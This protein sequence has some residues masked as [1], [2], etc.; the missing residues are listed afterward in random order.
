VPTLLSYVAIYVIWGSTFLAIRMAVESIP[1][2]LMMGVRCTVAGALLIAAGA[3]RRERPTLGDWG[4]GVVAGA[5][6]F[7]VPYAALGWAE[8]RIASGTAALLVATVP[9]WLVLVEWAR[10][11]RPSPCGLAGFAIGFGGVALLVAHAWATPA[12]AAPMAAIVV[13][14]LAWAIGSVYLQPR[15]PRALT[16]NAG[17][18]LTC[19]GVMLL[20]WSAAAGEPQAFSINTVTTSSG[21]ALAYLIVFGSI[22]AFSAYMFLL[23]VVP[24]SRVSTHAYVN[25]VI[26]VGLGAMFGGEALTASVVGA[27]VVIACGVALVLR[28]RHAPR[29]VPR[30][31]GAWGAHPAPAFARRAPARQASGT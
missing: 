21:I 16:L 6:M 25:P 12:S 15:L 4:P 2:L 11:A 20:M 3:I 13:S 9:L 23:R 10:G 26:A 17:M 29:K 18:P 5:L 14:E 24:A 31:P 8:Q 22:V 19:G 30:G 7:G 1:P 28:A 27:T